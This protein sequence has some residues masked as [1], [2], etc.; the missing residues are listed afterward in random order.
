MIKGTTNLWK[1]YPF[2]H[3]CG[4]VFKA[5]MI[6]LVYSSDYPLKFPS[7][8]LTDFFGQRGFVQ[9]T[10]DIRKLPRKR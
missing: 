4:N 3:F 9:K 5:N 10:L 6:A 2:Y 7:G 8:D 1:R